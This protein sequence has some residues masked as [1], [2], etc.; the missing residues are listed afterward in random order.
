MHMAKISFHFTFQAPKTSSFATI[1]LFVKLQK[2]V[3][4]WIRI[5]KKIRDTSDLA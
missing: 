4:P 3:F 2:A 5:D 1:A